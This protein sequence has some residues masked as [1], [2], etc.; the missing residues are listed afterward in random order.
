[1]HFED[2]QRG[3]VIFDI[4][5][6]W[7]AHQGIS[8]RHDLCPPLETFEGSLETFGAFSEIFQKKNQELEVPRKFSYGLATIGVEIP[9]AWL[10]SR[11]EAAKEWKNVS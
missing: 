8:E 6:M 1:M 5:K 9:L 4:A 7:R 10:F 11:D 2:L 3:T